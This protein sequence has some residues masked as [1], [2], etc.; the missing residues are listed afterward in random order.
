MRTNIEKCYPKYAIVSNCGSH[1]GAICLPCAA[2]LLGDLV[3]ETSAG[4]PLDRFQPSWG[5]SWSDF[6]DFQHNLGPNLV[7]MSKES[8]AASRYFKKTKKQHKPTH[9]Q[10]KKNRTSC[11][12]L[13]NP[14]KFETPGLFCMTKERGSS[15][16]QDGL[17]TVNLRAGQK[18]TH[19]KLRLEGA[20]RTKDSSFGVSCVDNRLVNRK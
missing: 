16:V 19:R 18:L 11:V 9:N 13:S 15:K 3:F 8:R 4:D 5:H 7:Q 2:P 1:V 6:L 14:R 12:C 20:A 17:H 10:S